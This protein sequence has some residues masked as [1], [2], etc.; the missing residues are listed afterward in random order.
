MKNIRKWLATSAIALTLTFGSGSLIQ[1]RADAGSGGPQGQQDS[2]SGGPSAA[3]VMTP[4]EY[5]YFL[6]VIVMW[7]LGWL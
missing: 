4:E 7:L 6:W 3:D 2:R 1:V 5:E